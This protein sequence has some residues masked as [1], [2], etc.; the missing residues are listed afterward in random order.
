MEN[1]PLCKA[2]LPPDHPLLGRSERLDLWVSKVLSHYGGDDPDKII[3][4]AIIKFNK[5]NKI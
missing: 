4:E 2:E 5:A 3:K 1:C